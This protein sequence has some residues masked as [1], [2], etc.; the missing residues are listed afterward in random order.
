MHLGADADVE[1][2]SLAALGRVSTFVLFASNTAALSQHAS[3]TLP[4]ATFAETDGTFVNAQGRAQEFKKALAPKGDS[5]AAWDA[6]ARL[7]R[8]MKLDVAYKR[9]AQVR[10]ALTERG[11]EPKVGPI[12]SSVDPRTSTPRAGV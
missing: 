8:A 4:V 1:E 11:L 3:I 6:I 2:A 7:G 12:D 10:A 9:F 5:V